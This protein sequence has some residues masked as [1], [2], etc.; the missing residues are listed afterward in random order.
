MLE[1]VSVGEA[2]P[3]EVLAALVAVTARR[4]HSETVAV[5]GDVTVELDLSADPTFAELSAEVAGLAGPAYHVGGIRLDVSDGRASLH[6]TFTG[7]VERALADGTRA[8][9]LRVS[10]LDLASDADRRLVATFEGG[11]PPPAP[12]RLVHDLV[13]ERARLTP[14]AP[15]LTA[16]GTTVPYRRLAERAGVL[17]GRLVEAGVRPGEVVGVLGDRSIGLITGLLAVLKA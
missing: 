2:P 17:A 12:P 11:N 10:E 8:P 16:G 3:R 5:T 9:S 7:Q 6:G 14:D 13:D 4:T 1:G 15:A